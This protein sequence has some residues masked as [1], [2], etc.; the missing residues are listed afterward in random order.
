MSQR[1][2]F[3]WVNSDLTGDGDV[4][5]SKRGCPSRDRVF[6]ISRVNIGVRRDLGALKQGNLCAIIQV[7]FPC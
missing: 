1:L 4:P 7:Q 6:D 5:V 2:V 3:G